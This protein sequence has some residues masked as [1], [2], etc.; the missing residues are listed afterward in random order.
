M[1]ELEESDFLE[2]DESEDDFDESDEDEDFDDSDDDE[3]EA[4]ELP[5]SFL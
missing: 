1:E 2:L 3:L 4:P 5:W